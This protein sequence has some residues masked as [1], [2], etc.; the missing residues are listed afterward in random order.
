[1]K[2][3]FR[4]LDSESDLIIIGGGLAGLTLEYKSNLKSNGNLKIFLIEKTSNLDGNSINASSGI[5][6]IETE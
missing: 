6:C 5:N 1:M 4:K 2:K 3:N